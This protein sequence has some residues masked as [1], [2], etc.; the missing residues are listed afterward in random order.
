MKQIMCALLPLAMLMAAAP[1]PDPVRDRIIADARAMNPGTLAF[2]RITT[3]VRK[4][5]GSTTTIHLVER[6]DGKAWTLI[7]HNGKPPSE[8]EKRTAE[9]IATASPAP[10]YYRLADLLAAASDSSID[11][12]GRTILHIPQLPPGSVR[13]DK[14]DISSHLRA[15]AIVGTHAGHAF[16]ERVHV[17]AREGFKLNLL[18]KVTS[19]EQISDYKIDADGHPR[20]ASQS[21]DSAGTMFGFPGGETSQITYAYR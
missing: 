19:F 12:Q 3:T 11:A 17:S 15:D 7:S 10:G 2:D 8:S 6:W 4:G 13:T 18:I 16:V 21:A 1:A 14:A 9:K 20:L 5:G